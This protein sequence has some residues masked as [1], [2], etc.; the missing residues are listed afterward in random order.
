[1][2]KS[3]LYIVGAVVLLGGGAY[4]FLKNKKTKDASKLADLQ[5]ATVGVATISTTKTPE[6]PAEKPLTSDE[7]L[8][9]LD[10]K[11]QITHDLAVATQGFP[12]LRFVFK[13][14]ADDNI[15]KLKTL[16][17]K[18]DINNNLVKI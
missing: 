3:I 5:N 6:V 10:L 9:L 14:K 16:G 13:K 11:N 17:Y 18:L 8:V 2:K 12:S 7:K 15:E 4:F 1:M